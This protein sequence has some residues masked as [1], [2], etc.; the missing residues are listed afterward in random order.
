MVIDDLEGDMA[1]HESCHCFGAWATG[2]KI[3]AA[4][5]QGPTLQREGCLICAYASLGRLPGPGEMVDADVRR[6]VAGFMLPLA[7]E[8]RM[9]GRG[10]SWHDGEMAL[11]PL[12][13]GRVKERSVIDAAIQYRDQPEEFYRAVKPMLDKLLDQRAMR[14]IAAGGQA[15]KVEGRMAGREIAQVFE[16]TCQGDLPEGVLPASEHGKRSG[17][18]RPTGGEALDRALECL[19]WA[20]ELLESSQPLNEDENDLVER[21]RERILSI[22]MNFGGK[23]YE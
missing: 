15:L 12:A 13:F 19:S 10:Q 14:C 18:P 23:C 17:R 4:T 22:Q 20:R 7:Y 9:T 8:E 3:E 11:R 5:I 6:H 21:L 1:T 16:E 2:G